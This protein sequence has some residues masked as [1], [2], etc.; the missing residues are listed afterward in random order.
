MNMDTF[1]RRS[2]RTQHEHRA[3]QLADQLARTLRCFADTV[4]LHGDCESCATDLH[5]CVE[6]A[7]DLGVSVPVPG[8]PQEERDA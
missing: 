2:H 1:R 4:H 7:R 8:D 3:D 6:K 5:I